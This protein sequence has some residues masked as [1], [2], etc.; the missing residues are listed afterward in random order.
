MTNPKTRI[1]CVEFQVVLIGEMGT[2]YKEHADE[3]LSDLGLDFYKA[4]TLKTK[5]SEHSVNKP[6]H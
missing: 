2:I 6:L 5:L 1:Q 4:K 3:P